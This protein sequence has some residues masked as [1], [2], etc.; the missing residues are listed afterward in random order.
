MFV[1]ALADHWGVEPI[2]E[3]GKAVYFAFDC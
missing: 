2:A 3:G 1:N